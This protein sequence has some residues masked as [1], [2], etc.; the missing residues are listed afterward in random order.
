MWVDVIGRYDIYVRLLTL[1]EDNAELYD[2]NS[3]LQL[4]AEESD[5]II[6][7]LSG[8]LYLMQ[9]VRQ[10]VLLRLD[11]ALAE[12]EATYNY[13]IVS[14]EHILPQSPAANS[15]WTEWFTTEDERKY[16]VHKIGNLA[17]LSRKKNSQ[18][19]NYDFDKK[20]EKYFVTD[21]GVSPFAL[22]TQ[23]LNEA[24]WTP[25]VIERRQQESLQKLKLLWR[26]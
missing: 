10:F 5:A 12:G 24:E 19:Q 16:Y 20:K 8:D 17:L 26:L 2:S 3:P 9:R 15:V 18:A 4:S 1:V 14:V 6:K 11:S 21:G 23:V 25:A 7:I 13:P 22:T